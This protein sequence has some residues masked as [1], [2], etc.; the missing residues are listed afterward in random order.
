MR[1]RGAIMPGK[2]ARS[3]SPDRCSVTYPEI[4]ICICRTYGL[5]LSWRGKYNADRTHLP[6]VVPQGCNEKLVPEWGA[7]RFVVHQAH[8]CISAAGGGELDVM[9]Q[10]IDS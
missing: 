9:K 6:R 3:C 5:L 10:S 4:A 2:D 1:A 8:A 7:V